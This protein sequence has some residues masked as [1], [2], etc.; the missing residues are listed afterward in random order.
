V[1]YRP[2]SVDRWPVAV[3]GVVRGANEITYFVSL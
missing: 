2:D 1:C 3:E